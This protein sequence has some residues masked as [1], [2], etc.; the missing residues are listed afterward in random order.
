VSGPKGNLSKRF[1]A[2]VSIEV[3]D[4]QVIVSPKG[5]SRHARAMHGTARSIVAN[6]VQ[7]VVEGFSKNLEINGVGF[8]A[9]MKGNVL[10]M[11]LGY[12]HPIEYPIPEGIQVTVVDNVKIKVE[13]A[14]KQLV[15]EVAAKI[16]R[17]YPVEPYKGN[18]V[19]IIGE[20]VRR[21]EGKK[22]A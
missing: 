20:Y 13:G 3:T 10:D 6:M 19:R 11:D 7:G 15:G 8:K 2:S 14:D 18:G 5:G 12:S 17:Y 1:E 16:K 21:K 9:I 4:S 22:T